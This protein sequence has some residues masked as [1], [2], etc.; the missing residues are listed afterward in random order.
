[1]PEPSARPTSQPSFL[2]RLWRLSCI[3]WMS[4][5]GGRGRLLLAGAIALE[6]GLVFGNVQLAQV[7]LQLGDALQ[8]RDAALFARGALAFAG[9][10]TG[11]RA[12]RRLSGLHP[13]EPR[14]ALASLAQRRV[15]VALDES[16]CVHPVR[17]ELGRD[18]QP[19][20]AHRRGH[21][22]LRRERTR[23]LALAPRRRCQLRFVRRPAVEPV[24]QLAHPDRRARIPDPRSPAS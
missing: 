15:P 4:R 20:P 11:D 6:F 8:Q 10:A 21:P 18:R 1:V 9:V 17:A 7:Q 3:Y 12:G 24:R 23:A 13:T 19:G 16:R 22:Q 2:R 5:D 14:D